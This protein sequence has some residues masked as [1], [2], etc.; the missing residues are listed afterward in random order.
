[1]STVFWIAF[2]A[3]W[4]LV[5]VQGIL[6]LLV[7]RHFGLLALDTSEGV[8]RDGLLVGQVAPAIVGVNSAGASVPWEPPAGESALLLFASTDCGPC[9]EVLPYVD[10]LSTDSDQR[11]S[12][13]TVVAGPPERAGELIE[14]F[15]THHLCLAEDGNRIFDTYRVRVT[16]FAFIVGADG[17]VRNKGVCAS[18]AKLRRLLEGGGLG[19]AASR[20]PLAPVEADR[21]NGGS[22]QKD[23]ISV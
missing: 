6:L 1:V 19:T 5:L 21:W 15:K 4:L 23:V 3:L 14:K 17:R 12:V 22:R 20:V 8:E 10:A 13:L 11:L 16:P 2:G 7:Y 18:G 9:A